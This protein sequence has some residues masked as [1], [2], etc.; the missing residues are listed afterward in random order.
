MKNP[1]IYPAIGLLKIYKYTLSPAFRA[2]GIHC[3]H[4]PDCANY[5]IGAFWSHGVWRGVWLTLSRL[6]RCHPWGSSGIDPVPK[7]AHKAP[8]WAPWKLG[9][10]KW[11]KRTGD[12]SC[13]HKE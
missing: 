11:T 2:M 8:L 13:A 5:S 4:E 6:S 3:R 7:C 10:W 1:F 12:H 9:D